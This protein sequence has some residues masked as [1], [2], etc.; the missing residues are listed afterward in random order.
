MGATAC[1]VIP[2]FADRYVDGDYWRPLAWWIH[3]HLPYS[4]LQF[5]RSSVPSTSSGTNAPANASRLYRAT[6]AIIPTGMAT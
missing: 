3:D 1:I 2:W 5:S 4:D 6:R